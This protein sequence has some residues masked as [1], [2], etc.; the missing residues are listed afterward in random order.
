MPRP[1]LLSPFVYGQTLLAQMAS[2]LLEDSLFPSFVC[3]KGYPFSTPSGTVCISTCD[4]PGFCIEWQAG[5]GWELEVVRSCTISGPTATVAI[6]VPFAETP[7]AARH[8]WNAL[9]DTALDAVRGQWEDVHDRNTAESWSIQDLESERFPVSLTGFRAT[10]KP[11]TED[12]VFTFLSQN[13]D[14]YA[15]QDLAMSA[16]VDRL[17][18]HL[19]ANRYEEEEDRTFDVRIEDLES[20]T[21]VSH[22]GTL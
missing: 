18:E 16:S 21:P 5:R 20:R 6:P 13:G 4:V 1:I 10:R 2:R 14:E 17:L 9:R 3:Q 19:E 7:H 8:L 22:G 11:D 12:V 15:C